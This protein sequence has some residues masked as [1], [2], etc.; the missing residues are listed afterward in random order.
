MDLPSD[1]IAVSVEEAGRMLGYKRAA[2]YKL[3]SSGEIPGLIRVGKSNRVSV[4][5][6]RAWVERKAT[7]HGRVKRETV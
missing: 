4:G 7:A 6:L 2:A 5:T 3:F 1:L